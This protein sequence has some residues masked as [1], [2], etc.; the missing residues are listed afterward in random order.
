MALKNSSDNKKERKIGITKI[1][2]VRNP[3]KKDPN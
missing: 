3:S 1:Q 2:Q